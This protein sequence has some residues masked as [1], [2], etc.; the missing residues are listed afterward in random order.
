MERPS[1]IQPQHLMKFALVYIRQ[2]S[3]QQVRDSS[4]SADVQRQLAE[5]ARQWGWP[6]SRIHVIDGD[7]GV[8]GSHSSQRQAFH[9]MLDLMDRGEVSIV[10][11]NAASRLSRTPRDAEQFLRIATARGVLLDINR[12]LFSPGDAE[13]IELFHLRLQNL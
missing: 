5:R 3:M 9:Q 7:L 6:D 2:S 8:S 13:V 12:K 4:G 11:V 1:Q 10:F